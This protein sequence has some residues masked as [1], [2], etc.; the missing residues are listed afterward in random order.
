GAAD[1]VKYLCGRAPLDPKTHLYEHVGPAAVKHVFRVAASLD[2]QV[3]GEPQI[4]GQLKQAYGLAAGAGC[5]GPL[6]GR[7]VGR[8]F[9]VAKRVRSET[10][11]AAGTVSVSSVAVDLAKKV[12]GDLD[13]KTVLVIGAGK[14]SDL[15]ARY[16]MD[17]GAAE[18]WVTNRTAAR[19]EEL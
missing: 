12:F 5:V 17:D 2:S 19:A 14:M 15:A 6:L 3:V 9:G 16:L 1:L 18:L 8:A 13:G 7:C 11:I 10:Q 4:L